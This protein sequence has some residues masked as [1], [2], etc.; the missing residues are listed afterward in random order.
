MDDV[1]VLL[2]CDEFIGCGVYNDICFD[3]YVW[4]YV[5][6]LIWMVKMN[7]GFENIIYY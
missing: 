1:C 6:K 5:K 3:W 2:E 7:V 4:L